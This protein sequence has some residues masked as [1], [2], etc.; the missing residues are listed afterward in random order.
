MR[1]H[2]KDIQLNEETVRPWV[3]ACCMRHRKRYD[4]QRLFTD[5]GMDKKECRRA[6]EDN[7]RAAFS[8]AIDAICSDAVERIRKRQL[9][10]PPV[11]IEERVD[12]ASGKLRLIGRES[13]MQQ[14]LDHIAVYGAM[15][16]F[17]CRI[18]PE[19]ASSIPGRGQIYGIHMIH[20]WIRQDCQAKRYADMHGVRYAR[21]TKWFVKLDVQK[22]YPTA[23]LDV[24]MDLFRKDCGNADLLWL[25][26]TLLLTH[27]VQGYTGFMIGALPSQWACQYMMSFIY[28]FA[29]NQGKNRRGK[30]VGAVKHMLVYLDDMLLMGSN[31]GQLRKAVERIVEFA[32]SEL[33]WTIKPNWNIR[34]IDLCDIDMM[35]FTVRAD[36]SVSIRGRNFVHARRVLLRTQNN[37]TLSQ[38]YRLTSFKGYF[39][40]SNSRTVRQELHLDAAANRAS[41]II[42]E[43]ERSQQ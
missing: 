9:G 43:H 40:H 7:D 8:D 41:R 31:R 14:V 17:K 19:Q 36:G 23:R 33:G 5:H 29:R 13:A 32:R 28:R 34:S 38:A 18:V 42:S 24:F 25:W 26:E 27:R 1:T 15:D 10:L 4:F 20:R 11:L 16:V 35:G 21:K 37:M 2:C 30:F 12:D 6:L 39:D 22:C 3:E